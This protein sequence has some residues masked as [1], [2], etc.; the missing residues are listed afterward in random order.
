MLAVQANGKSIRTIEGLSDGYTYDSLHPIQ[1]S[2]VDTMAF[3]C[4]YCTSAQ[5]LAAVPL[6][7]NGHK[8]SL[9]EVKWNQR[10][11]LCRCG[12]YPKI[13]RAVLDAAKVTTFTDP[14]R[15][16]A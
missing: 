14:E 11:V 9:E 5:I 12:C 16:G 8:P 2:F 15:V 6:L 4:A 7:G 3:Q 13:F 1:K 10:G